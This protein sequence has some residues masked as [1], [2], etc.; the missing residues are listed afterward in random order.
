MSDSMINREHTTPM[1]R[2]FQSTLLAAL[3]LAGCVTLTPE[4][5]SPPQEN[6]GTPENAA[7]AQESKQTARP[8]KGNQSPP[9]VPKPTPPPSHPSVGNPEKLIGATGKE[10]IA[11]FGQPNMSMDVT[12]PG[13][14]TAEGY[15]YYPKEGKGCIHTFLVQPD[16]DKVIHYFCQ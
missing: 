6:T 11:R 4:P 2:V 12:M 5:S 1:T 14:I 8:G 15:L 10:L 13:H 16:S 9:A 3:L 7:S